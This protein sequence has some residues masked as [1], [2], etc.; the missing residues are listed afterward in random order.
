MAT[1][2]EIIPYNI[3][4]LKTILSAPYACL[5]ILNNKLH[6]VYFQ[7]YFSYL[8]AKTVVIENDYIDKDYLND[9]MA[10]YAN[11]FA[12]YERRCKRLHFFDI[13]FTEANFDELL[14][15]KT[16]IIDQ[17]KLNEAYLGFIVAK[18][19]PQTIIGRTCLK[20]Y[21][22]DKGRRYYSV[23]RNYDV[24]LFGIDLKVASLAFQEQDHVVSAC[25]TS[26]LWSVFQGTGKLFQHPILSPADITKIAC[27]NSLM[28]TRYLPNQGLLAPQMAQAIREVD[29]EPFLVRPRREENLRATL[30]AYLKGKVPILMGVLLVD[31][32]KDD[33]KSP[34]VFLGK[35]AVAVTGYSLGGSVIPYPLHGFLLKAS[36]ID[37]IYAHDDQ[38]GPFSRIILDMKKIKYLIVDGLST[39]RS[40]KSMKTSWKGESKIIGS[41]RAIPELLLIPLYHKIRIPFE[42]VHDAVMYFDSYIEDIRRAGIMSI[43][44][45]LL[46]DI[47]LTT[48]NE[49]KKEIFHSNIILDNL[50]KEFLQQSMPR[51]LW[52]ASA[53][54]AGQ[55]V[56]DLLFDATDIEQAQFARFAIG[57]DQS[58][59]SDLVVIAQASMPKLNE[60]RPEWKVLN[61]FKEYEQRKA[62]CT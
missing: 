54:C 12:S 31:G 53:Y 57:Y 18:P 5:E 40:E 22:S 41:V 16:T 15:G 19:L 1:P 46:W 11:C 48:N 9:F 29:L 38:V 56:L 37:K 10:F 36:K 14:R 52:R 39:E 28:D 62:S 47:Y 13:D 61:Y 17:R 21:D 44:E 33:F 32:S 7:E 42:S 55:I 3:E 26:A 60:T 45:R 6:S 30:Y 2:Y 4:T 49:I 50:K 35:H 59:F 34:G 51:Y 43:G 8:N 20:T 27:D 25:A 24:N 58:L 23:V